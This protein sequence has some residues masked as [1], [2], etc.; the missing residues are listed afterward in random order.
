MTTIRVNP[1][2]QVLAWAVERAPTEL[3]HKFQQLDKWL[4]GDEKPTLRQLEDFARAAA[5]PFGY[6]F[7]SAPPVEHLPIPYFRTIEEGEPAKPPSSELLETIYI[8]QHRQA[9]MREYLIEQGQDP[10]PFVHSVSVHDDPVRVARE[11]RKIL[12]IEDGW[13]AAVQTWTDALRTL[14][15]KTED[16]GILV[17]TSGIVGN[18]TRQKLSVD[19]FRGFVLVD[20]YAPLVFMN[21][22]DSKA[23]QMF[24]L[25]HELAHVWYGSSAAFD[26]RELHPARNRLEEACNRVAAELLVPTE[27]LQD[28]WPSV[29]QLD[30]RFQ[31]IARHFKVSEIVAARR[32]LDLGHITRDE[33]FSFYENY[34]SRERK[35]STSG[36][37]GGNFYA[38]Q[39]LRLGR[40]FA[41]AVIQAVQ[42]GAL[43]YHEAYRLTGLYGQTFERFVKHFTG[44]LQ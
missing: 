22:A 30:D 27:E 17:V 37:T 21:G 1:N 40:R 29:A 38:N 35:A 34:Q 6:F 19:E 39:T 7:L 43:L 9:W 14:Q 18:N 13:A 20:E 10:L 5:V 42:E 41:E 15:F 36:D 12:S 24:T 28:L 44:A 33:F 2:P 3:R 23:A 25:A 4:S 16:A 8:M 32:A 11:I 26:L 31:A